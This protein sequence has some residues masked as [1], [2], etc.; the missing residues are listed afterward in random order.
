[1]SLIRV[2]IGVDYRYLDAVHV[3]AHFAVVKAVI[4]PLYGWS[5]ENPRRVLKGNTMPSDVCGVLGRIPREPILRDYE[6]Y[7]PLSRL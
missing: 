6:M 7:L 1:M 4:S 2:A 5:V 3:D